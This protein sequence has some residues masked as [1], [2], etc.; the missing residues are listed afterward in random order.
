MALASVQILMPAMM[1]ASIHSSIMNP[2]WTHI[3]A[4]LTLLGGVPLLWADQPIRI[5]TYNIQHFKVEQ[6]AGRL[7][8]LT[9][10]L[11]HIQPDLVGMQE[12]SN[13]AALEQ[14]FNKDRWY[15]IIDDDSVPATEEERDQ[16]LAFAV[17]K[18]RFELIGMT[19][20]HL[21]ADD[22]DFL[23]PQAEWDEIFRARRDVLRLKLRVKGSSPPFE[24]TVLTNHGKSRLGGRAQTDFLRE[25]A[26]KAIIRVLKHDYADQAVVFM[27]DFNDNPDDRS[28][29]ILETGDPNAPAGPQ[30]KPGTLLVNLTEPL[31]VAGHV[32]EGLGPRS[33]KDG[34]INTFDPESRKRNN[35]L[36]GTDKNTGHILFDQILASPPMAKLCVPGSV[37]VCDYPAALEGKRNERTS[38]HLP[39]HADFVV[40]GNLPTAPPTTQPLY[41]RMKPTTAPASPAVPTPTDRK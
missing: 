7:D 19:E 5:A 18:E 11:E 12:I 14:L 25:A 29:N 6:A 3:G 34:K 31:M 35:D 16:D 13:R 10:V 17:R 41:G 1:P 2:M 20:D 8:R 15:L 22:K 38:D 4:V 39:V 28:L 23:F 33:V 27:G 36:R 24:F 30:E 26:S 32:S 9:Q 40:P 21:N 37:K